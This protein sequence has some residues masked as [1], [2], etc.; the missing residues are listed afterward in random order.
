[1]GF[2]VFIDHKIL[3]L[4]MFI[5]Y[6][7]ATYPN[8]ELPC[9]NRPLYLIGGGLLQVLLTNRNTSFA[10]RRA[11]FTSCILKELLCPRMTRLRTLVSQV[12]T[13]AA[14]KIVLHGRLVQP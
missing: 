8:D 9:H 14:P 4:L 2:G 7:G 10:R 12:V 11:Q 13:T 1:M 3:E 5:P 6:C